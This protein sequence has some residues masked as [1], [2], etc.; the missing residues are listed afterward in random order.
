MIVSSVEEAEEV[1]N[2]VGDIGQECGLE[3]NKHKSKIIIFNMKDKPENI[4]DINVRDRL[5]YLGILVNENRNCFR[6]QSI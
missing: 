1:I 5:K 6:I 4:A 3:I 2:K